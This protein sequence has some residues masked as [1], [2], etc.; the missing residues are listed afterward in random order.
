VVTGLER[1]VEEQ[2]RSYIGKEALERISAE[3]VSRK[4]VG[5]EIEGDPLD[6][7]LTQFWPAHSNGDRV[8]HATIAIRSP[9]LEMNIGYVWV[10]IELA[11]PGN[12]LEPA[13]ANHHQSPRI[14]ADDPRGSTISPAKPLLG[15]RIRS[16]SH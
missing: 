3:G 5:M 4:L 14:R 6:W 7:E 11:E 1:L 8:G 9:G 2:G 15:R 16:V 13:L 12:Q 10:P